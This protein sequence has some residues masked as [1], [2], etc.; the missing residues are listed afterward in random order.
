MFIARRQSLFLEL[1]FESI[2]P[3]IFHEC[4]I[5]SYNLKSLRT[6]CSTAM[7]YCDSDEHASLILFV[8]WLRHTTGCL[9]SPQPEQEGNRL[10]RPNS[11][12]IQHGPHAVQNTSQPVAL[13][14]ASH[15]KKNSDCCPSNQVSAA[16]MTSASDEIQ[17]TFNCFFSVHGTGGSPTWPDPENRVGD[18]DIGSLGR[19]VSFGLQVPGETGHCRT[20]TRPLW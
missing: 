11:G 20:R 15:S 5:T 6:T 2:S 1:H 19:P 16:A 18:Q 9:I 12:F 4:K 13:T 14:S 3:T 8:F 10:Q 7:L 17:R